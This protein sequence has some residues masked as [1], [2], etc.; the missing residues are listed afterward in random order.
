MADATIPK[1]TSMDDVDVLRVRGRVRMVAR[2][3]EEDFSCRSGEDVKTYNSVNDVY[4]L[5]VNDFSILKQ[6]Y[7]QNLANVAASL[8]PGTLLLSVGGAPSDEGYMNVNITTQV[9]ES[10]TPAG[11]IPDA[12]FFRVVYKIY[13]LIGPEGT[14]LVRAIGEFNGINRYEVALP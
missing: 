13:N 4:A 12:R 8:G 2:Y 6:F 11:E 1:L 7:M 5:I 14:A 3:N 10:E 9:T